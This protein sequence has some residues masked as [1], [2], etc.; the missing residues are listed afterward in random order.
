M[1]ML[2]FWLPVCKANDGWAGM[3]WAG[4]DHDS[5]F[6]QKLDSKYMY[7][8]DFMDILFSVFKW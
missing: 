7:I 4:L 1:N 8:L 2:E 5:I 6:T 3:R